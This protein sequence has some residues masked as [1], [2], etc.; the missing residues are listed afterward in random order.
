MPLRRDAPRLLTPRR[1]AER[2]TSSYLKYEGTTM[3]NGLQGLATALILLSSVAMVGCGTNDTTDTSTS[4]TNNTTTGGTEGPPTIT[5]PAF[6]N[7]QGQTKSTDAYPVGATGIGIGSIIPNFAFVGFADSVA[8]NGA[9]QEVKL[10]DFYNASGSDQYAAGLPYTGAKPK[11]LLIDVSAV[12]CGPCNQES[13]TMLPGK[14][15]T[16]HPQG[17]EFLLTLADGPNPGTAA[18]PDDL[19]GWTGRYH[20]EFPAVI[21]PEY[22]L[23]ALFSQDA[24]PANMFINTQNMRVCHVTAGEPQ[25]ADW[26]VFQDI[27]DGKNDCTGG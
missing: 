10:S 9:M 13:D 24:F 25:D 2:I 20:E 3:R 4:G 8:N 27:L 16:Y 12:W 15:T 21:D 19:G 1:D 14:Y 22:K 6:P 7:G 11:A 26:A 5:V 18:T 23:A 17:G